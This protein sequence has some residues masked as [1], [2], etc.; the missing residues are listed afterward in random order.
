MH[1]PLVGKHMVDHVNDLPLIPD[2]YYSVHL[3]EFV[4]CL[5]PVAL[6]QTSGHNDLPD[7][8]LRL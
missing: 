1:H 3:R 7:G 4:R 8:A 5:L 2:A 6:C